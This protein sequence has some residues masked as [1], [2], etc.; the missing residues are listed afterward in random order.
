MSASIQPPVETLTEPI[1][2]EQPTHPAPPMRRRRSR[3]DVALLLA[4]MI[5]IG[6]AAFAAGR[7]TAPTAAAASNQDCGP[8][9][10]GGGAPG[11]S[12]QPEPANPGG[13]PNQ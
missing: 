1:S 10:G 3:V 6:G 5:A 4:G 12:G 2:P 7:V 9:G 13:N 11:A 8:G